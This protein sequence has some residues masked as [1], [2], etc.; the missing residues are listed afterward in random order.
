MAER[1]RDVRFQGGTSGL[2]LKL[3]ECLQMDP[4][5][6]YVS[7]AAKSMVALAYLYAASIRHRAVQPT[8]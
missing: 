7:T 2:P 4:K 5:R 1:D 6:T 8:D 3:T